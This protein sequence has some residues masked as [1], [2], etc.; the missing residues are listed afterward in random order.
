MP[1]RLT[2]RQHGENARHAATTADIRKK[3]VTA[4]PCGGTTNRRLAWIDAPRADGDP[5]PVVIRFA[6][7]TR[8]DPQP[9]ADRQRHL[10][11]APPI[12]RCRP[13]LRWP[14]LSRGRQL[15]WIGISGNAIW[16]A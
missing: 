7:I 11:D 6:P 13:L 4:S 2:L 8:V 16:P 1:S 5:E 14:S 12:I 10:D 3:A 15:D 9:L